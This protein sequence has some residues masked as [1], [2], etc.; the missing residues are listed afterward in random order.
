MGVKYSLPPSL[1]H[2]LTPTLAPFLPHSLPPFLPVPSVLPR[3]R[4]KREAALTVTQAVTTKRAYQHL[5]WAKGKD[6]REKIR[7]LKEEEVLIKAFKVLEPYSDFGGCMRAEGDG[8][9]SVG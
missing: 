3:D 4:F 5:A 1:P 8:K 2:S 9:E 7:R 6:L